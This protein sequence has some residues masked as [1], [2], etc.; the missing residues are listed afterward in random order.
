MQFKEVAVLFFRPV[1]AIFEADS[2]ILH[3]LCFGFVIHVVVLR[4]LHFFP[5][6][7]GSV[8]DRIVGA[9]VQLF[10]DFHPLDFFICGEVI[11]NDRVF[12]CGPRVLVAF[13]PF[14][15]IVAFDHFARLG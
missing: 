2:S 7:S 3:E 5:Q 11:Q 15:R 4:E 6:P 1:L 13:D 14:A 9:I 10:R 8:S 12:L